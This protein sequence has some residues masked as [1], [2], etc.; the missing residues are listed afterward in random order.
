MSFL[1]YPVGLTFS[2]KHRRHFVT[3]RLHHAVFIIDMPCPAN[4]TLITSGDEPGHTNGHG[5]KAK[6][7]NSAGVEVRDEKLYVCDQGNST[8]RVVNIRELFSHTSRID[9]DDAEESQS[10]EEDCA[11]RRFV[12]WLCTNFPLFSKKTYLI[13]YR[14][15]PCM[16]RQR[17]SLNFLNR[18][19]VSARF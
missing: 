2:P 3:D 11:V 7:K 8:I 15:M 5:N 13:W 6:F 17:M 18:M 19:F 1:T 12:K 14:P 9:Q 4:I 16:L 10:E